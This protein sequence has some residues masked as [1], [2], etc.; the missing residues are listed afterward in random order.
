MAFQQYP[1]KF[2]IPSG[3]TAGRPSNPII[4]DTYY[5]GQTEVLEIYNGTAWVAASAPPAVPS[6]VSVTDVGT[7]LAYATGGTFTVVVAPGSGG[8]TP[9]QY[10]ISTS[11]GGFSATTSGTTASL[12]GLTPGTSFVVLANAQNNFGTTVNSSPFSA[13]TAT[14]V[15]QAP[16]IGTATASTSA[17]QITVTWTLN[18]NGGK[19]LSAVIITPY[20]NGTTAET[21]QTAAT[22]S[23]TSFTFT[24]AMITAGSNYTFKVKTTNANGTSLESSATNSATMPNN[25][26]VDYLVIAGGGGGGS[27]LLSGNT[28]S[29][30]GGGAGG[31]RSTVGTSGRGAAQ[32]TALQTTMSAKTVTVGA[33]GPGA[34]SGNSNGSTGNDS[35][36]STITSAGGGRGAKSEVAGGNGGA[37]GGAGS[38]NGTFGGGQGTNNQGY[39]GGTGTNGAQGGGGG[40]A[41]GAGQNGST[42]ITG[43]N[44]GSGQSSS[45]TGTSVTRAGGGGAG[46]YTGGSAGSG[47]GGAGGSSGNGSPGTQNT[48]G[49]GGGGGGNNNYTGGQGGSG[50]VILRYADT[51]TITIGAGL[52]GT[53]SA[54]SGGYKRATL[55]AGTGNV[56]W[57]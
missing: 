10:N 4:G 31:Y 52:T 18:A 33:G 12:T 38:G 14:T 29:G 15:P 53:E 46:S 32:E 27:G 45:I 48:G 56:S 1:Q 49:G 7:G 16:T 42:Y 51:F 41:G 50:V 3:N 37:G 24:T 40:G 54:A 28:E 2:G 25:I 43:G 30:G 21:A 22:T 6:I 34:P 47:G 9:L 17:N 26:T 23:S 20:L 39:D 11:A 57:S 13:V 8:S 55:T 19:N 5:N 44:G 36:F 35:V